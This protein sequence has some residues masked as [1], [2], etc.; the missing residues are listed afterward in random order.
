MSSP[1]QSDCDVSLSKA[2]EPVKRIRAAVPQDVAVLTALINDAFEVEAFF[3]IGDR[4]SANEV[5]RLMDTGAFLVLED[6][7]STIVG[8]VYLKLQD[9][10]AYFGMLSIAPSRQGRGLGRLLIEAVEER[11]RARGCRY[12]DI[13]IVNLREELPD[14]YRRL[15]YVDHGTLPFSDTD[16]ASQPCHFIVM[17]KALV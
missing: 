1:G 8:C 2:V 9:G 17:T 6:P 14:F 12:V 5:V 3:K 15:G 10:R 16:R 11:A 13:H 7:S 4:T